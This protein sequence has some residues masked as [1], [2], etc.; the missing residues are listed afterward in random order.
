MTDIIDNET[1]ETIEKIADIELCQERMKEISAFRK[2]IG[3]GPIFL[4]GYSFGFGDHI[5]VWIQKKQRLSPQDT[6]LNF[7]VVQN[8]EYFLSGYR[9]AMED[10]AKRSA[11]QRELERIVSEIEVLLTDTQRDAFRELCQGLLFEE[12]VHK[13]FCQDTGYLYGSAGKASATQVKNMLRMGL[14]QKDYNHP[15][16]ESRGWNNLGATYLKPSL[17]GRMLAEKLKFKISKPE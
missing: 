12:T 10:S 11:S 17:L 5:E 4:H 9:M 3:L 8:L 1:A 13:G 7:G 2:A 6:L 16:N 15:H 14:A